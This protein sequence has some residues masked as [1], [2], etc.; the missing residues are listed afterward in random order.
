MINEHP[1]AGLAG[2]LPHWGRGQ[3]DFG[4]CL[5]PH[6]PPSWCLQGETGLESPSS[7]VAGL[8]APGLPLQP[9]TPCAG[10]APSLEGEH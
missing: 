5:L 9:L 4:G 7:G 10:A 1:A 8:L 6:K 2:M 3:R